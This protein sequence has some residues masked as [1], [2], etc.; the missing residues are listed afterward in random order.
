MKTI[1]A[2][3]LASACLVAADAD[4]NGRWNIEVTGQGPRVKWLDVQGAGTASL[5]GTFVGFPGGQVDRI[6]QIRIE[7]GW[8]EFSFERQPGAGQQQSIRHVYRG[9]LVGSELRGNFIAFVD[10][11]ESAPSGFCGKR[12]PVIKD[13]DD[14]SWK[15]GKTVE[16]VDGKSTAGWRQTVPSRPGWVVENGLLRN[17]EK[18][19]DIV[20]EAK[21]WNFELTAEYRYGKGSNSGIGLRGRYEVQIYDDYGKEAS[22]HGH[23][24]LYSRIRAG[25]GSQPAAGRVADHEG[26]A[27]GAGRDRDAER[28][29]RDREARCVWAYGD[30][31]RCGRG[32]AGADRAAGRSRA[33]RVQADQRDGTGEEVTNPESH[34]RGAGMGSWGRRG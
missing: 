9:Q 5:S 1:F 8:L 4:F 30:V 21:F 3:V 10:G 14:G 34:P 6:P 12:A 20:S 15:P 2:F 19:S 24:A 26:Q 27:G 25:K 17:L 23:G 11:K 32:Q 28:C 31:D 22:M 33:G 7:N 13:K 29:G 16:L 18:A